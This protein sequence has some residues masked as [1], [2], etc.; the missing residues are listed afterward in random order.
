[1]DWP[2]FRFLCLYLYGRDD[3]GIAVG[4]GTEFDA[5]EM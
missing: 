1:M 2:L 3:M 4:R 5:S